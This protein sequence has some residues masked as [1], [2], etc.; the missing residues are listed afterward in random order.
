MKVAQE[1]DQET[2][3]KNG[4]L[5]EENAALHA[6]VYAMTARRDE[7]GASLQQMM[8]TNRQ[9]A[10]AV[11]ESCM[12]EMQEKLATNAQAIGDKYRQD[13]I[14]AQSEYLDTLHELM[15]SFQE[16]IQ[17]KRLELS[18][19]ESVLAN[20][21]SLTNA[22]VEANK[23]A[24][25][26][27]EKANFYRLVLSEEDLREIERLREV[28]PYLRDSEPLNKVIWKVYYENPYTDMIGR[29][30]G[31]GVHT[32]IYKITNLENGMCYIGQAANIADR[33]KQHIKRGIGAETPTRNK[34]Y[35]AMLAIGV[36]N[37]T[38]EIVEECDRTKLNEREDYWQDY[39]KAKEFGYSIK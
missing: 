26:M 3:R 23:R 34:L 1:L 15:T 25:E 9:S 29:V 4:E 32:G 22:A 14:D 7:I 16:S 10:N 33:W 11:Y 6:E 30:V 27:A 39:F 19:V 8:E 13:E 12:N 36:E 31:K 2:I 35:P 20:M 28:T 18:E 37:F 17:S 24:Q 21:Q 5:Q 38:F